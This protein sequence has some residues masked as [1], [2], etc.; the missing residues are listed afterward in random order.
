MTLGWEQLGVGLLSAIAKRQGHDV[1]L[2]FSHSL[3][4]DRYN[5]SIPSLAPFFDDRNDVID[6]IEKQRPDVLAFSA[7]T[8]TYQWMLGIA[9]DAKLLNPGV[10]V[11]F[12]GVHPSAVPERVLAQP[13]VDYVCVGEGDVAFPALLRAIEEGGPAAPIPNIRYK[14]PN[15][16]V[17]R[18]PQAGFIQDLDA[19]PAFDKTLW[20]DHINIGDW[21]LTMASR[22]CPYRCTFCF[23][24][25][26]ARLPEGKSGKYVR[27]R[28]V[29]HMLQELR[30]AKKRYK[31]RFLEF[32]DDVFTVDK[33]WVREFL[34]H[35]KR[36]IDIPFQC[37]T[38][39]KYMD[40]DIAR[41]LSDAGCRH[42]Q[43][44]IQT[45]DDE[46]K[47]QSVKRYEKSDHVYQA[48]EVMRKYRL[49]PKVDHMFGL[50]GEPVEAQEEARK[51][52]VL[53]PPFRI[54]TFWTN[55]LPGTQLVRQGLAMGLITQEEVDRLNDGIDFD[56]YRE[57][58]KVSDPAKRKLYKT[59]E[60]FFKLIPVLPAW[61]R[62]RLKPKSFQWMPVALCSSISFFADVLV[63]LA[64]RNPD[65]ITY[66]KHY[67]YHISRFFLQK[68]GIRLPAPTKLNAAARENTAPKERP[69][70]ASVPSDV[71]VGSP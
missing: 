69:A 35:Y 52:Y 65:H 15:G 22:G 64:L 1:Q 53:H 16:E 17:I 40:E 67:L 50:P 34:Y 43:M 56:F 19:L 14:L 37:L 33:K 25:F 61:L 27:Q 9:R 47:Q 41:W 12:G 55:F 4:N 5:L 10:K 11:V 39:P 21:Y 30:A 26:F 48:M 36:E 70:G 38:H 31:I 28:S 51:L 8:G 3:F 54:Q 59:Y 58:A 29:G 63:G 62:R 71:L 46:F 57:S 24:N 2:A 45:M 23:N 18:G 20:E 13:Q 6:K 60:V 66:A 68:A 49:N 42:V 7:L 44:G 32:E